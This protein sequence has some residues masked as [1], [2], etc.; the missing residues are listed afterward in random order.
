M[1]EKKELF[2]QNKS[3]EVIRLNVY[4]SLGVSWA[5]VIT[6]ALFK[7]IILLGVLSLFEGLLQ[8]SSFPWSD[9]IKDGS[10]SSYQ[11]LMLST[12]LD[13]IFYPLFGFFLIQLWDFFIRLYAGFLG[14]TDNVK[15][16]IDG[17]LSVSLS[18]KILLI[19]PFLGPIIEGFAGMILMFAGLKKQ[20]NMKWGVA[21]CLLLTPYLF[22]LAMFSFFFLFLILLFM[23]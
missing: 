20:F 8:D 17:I 16:K 23:Y 9:Y 6:G 4:E 19:I 15:E 3:D 1:V 11:M 22:A 12:F 13:V 18:S 21:A 7:V 14:E 5:F 2:L 10:F